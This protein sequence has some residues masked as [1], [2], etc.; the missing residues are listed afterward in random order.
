MKIVQSIQI[1]FHDMGTSS[2][3][4]EDTYER[5]Y[6]D[7]AL[8]T[9]I[10]HIYLEATGLNGAGATTL[11]VELYDFTNSLSIATLDFTTTSRVRAK[12]ADIK[13]SLSAAVTL[14]IRI[15]RVGSS[16][17]YCRSTNIIVEQD[18]SLTNRKTASYY[19]LAS[20]IDI[21][22]NVYG[23]PAGD[24][25]DA[26]VIPRVSNYDGTVKAYFEGYLWSGA[27]GTVY[28][29]LYDVTAA[30]PVD[31]SEIS[32]S[33]TTPTHVRSGELTLDPTHKYMAQCKSS[34]AAKHA[35]IQN[36]FILIT[37]EGFTKCVSIA[38]AMGV[39]W[40]EETEEF[41][42]DGGI[43]SFPYDKITGPDGLSWV[44]QQLVK[45]ADHDGT[46]EHSR[47]YNI[48]QAGAVAGT[49]HTYTEL[50]TYTEF[51]QD[52][53]TVPSAEDELE[54][55][56]DYYNFLN[57]GACNLLALQQE[58][59]V[60][61]GALA[62]DPSQPTGYHCFMSQFVKNCL[63]GYIPLKTPDGANRCW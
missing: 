36:P 45:I 53:P 58:D 18:D 19:Q 40:I 44:F 59:F 34:D 6:F 9:N 32:T 15:K 31:G 16:T 5:V 50:G 41:V 63:A 52:T 14:G 61:V 4:Y 27:G 26:W 46:E 49:L 28:S 23:S 29:R 22:G 12:S 62:A 25:K 17:S 48:T 55:Q 20:W 7:P 33:E 30:A 56:Y 35:Y 47:I 3:S 43:Y 42:S 1:G 57:M 24:H 39:N 21:Y 11:T 13:A 38:V 51:Y 10:Q 2:S 8:F 54:Q 37:A 60:A